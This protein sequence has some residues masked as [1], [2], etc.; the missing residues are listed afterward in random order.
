MLSQTTGPAWC[1]LQ[2]FSVVQITNLSQASIEMLR[3]E[4]SS[5]CKTCFN[6]ELLFIHQAKCGPISIFVPLLR[7]MNPS[8]QLRFWMLS[9]KPSAP[10]V[11]SPSFLGSFT[12]AYVHLLYPRS[13]N[14]WLIS[15]DGTVLKQEPLCTMFYKAKCPTVISSVH[16]NALCCFSWC[17]TD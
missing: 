1:Y 7:I 8:G 12:S 4:L 5:A 17:V 16:D 6:T 2:W 14:H 3:T 9:I 10:I 15:T 11:K 13:G